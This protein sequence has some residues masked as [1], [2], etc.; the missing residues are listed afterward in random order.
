MV[1]DLLKKNVKVIYHMN[2]GEITPI[3]QNFDREQMY[4]FAK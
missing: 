4:G 2:D 1:I 3:I